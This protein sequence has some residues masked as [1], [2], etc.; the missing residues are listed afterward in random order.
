M[1]QARIFVSKRCDCVASAAGNCADTNRGSVSVTERVAKSTFEAKATS[2]VPYNGTVA[3]SGVT[4]MAM[5]VSS[6]RRSG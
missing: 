4:A 3:P 1:E 6:V 5:R 2:A